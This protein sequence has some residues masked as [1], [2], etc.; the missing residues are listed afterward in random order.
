MTQDVVATVAAQLQHAHGCDYSDSWPRCIL[1]VLRLDTESVTKKK[2]GG[3]VR[4]QNRIFKQNQVGFPGKKVICIFIEEILDV[5]QNCCMKYSVYFL[6]IFP[7]VY[8]MERIYEAR[9]GLAL[10]SK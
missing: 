10:K 3:R 1:L 5:L 8:T 7:L 4:R 6:I 9:E 2:R